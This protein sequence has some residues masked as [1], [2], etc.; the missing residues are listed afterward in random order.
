MRRA[1]QVGGG[2]KFVGPGGLQGGLRFSSPSELGA[3]EGHRRG[4]DT[5]C[6]GGSQAPSGC[7]QGDRA[8]AGLRL[9]LVWLRAQVNM[10]DSPSPGRC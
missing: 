3:M 1:G 5:V 10:D 6:L 2:V 8:R 7:C 4:R 9:A